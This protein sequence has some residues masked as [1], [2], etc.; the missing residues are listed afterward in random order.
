LPDD[1][2]YVTL[3]DGRIGRFDAS[4]TDDVIKSQ[5]LKDFPDAYGKAPSKTAAPVGPNPVTPQAGPPVSRFDQFVGDALNLTDPRTGTSL[6]D[7]FSGFQHY[8]NDPLKAAADWAG[9]KGS[10][11]MTAPTG[12]MTNRAMMGRFGLDPHVLTPEERGRASAIGETVGSTVGDIRNWPLML[13]GGPILKK[14]MGAGFATL[15]GANVIQ[16]SGE[17]GKVWDDNTPEGREARSKGLTGMTLGT[18]MAGLAGTGVRET[19]KMEGVGPKVEAPPTDVETGKIQPEEMASKPEPKAPGKPSFDT[20]VI[21][22]KKMGDSTMHRLSII[23]DGEE[24]GHISGIVDPTDPSTLQIHD[25]ELTAAERGNGLG[26]QAYEEFIN[27]AKE[28]GFSTLRSDSIV[29]PAAGRVWESLGKKGYDVQQVM[30]GLSGKQY[31]LR[32]KPEEAPAPTPFEALADAQRGTP[33]QA[34]LNI[35]RHPLGPGLYNY[36]VEHVGDLTHRMA[37]SRTDFGYET[38]K[39]KVTKSLRYL[40]QG[41]GFEKEVAQN[42]KN[43][44]KYLTEEKGYKGSFSDAENELKQR[45]EQYAQAHEQLP[46]V[47]AL[48]KTARDAA[49]ALGR[50]NF[51]TAR[52]KLT[53]LKT[54]LDKGKDAWTKAAG[55]TSDI[56]PAQDVPVDLGAAAKKTIT[57]AAT[58]KRVKQYMTKNGLTREDAGSRVYEDL[59]REGIEIPEVLKPQRTVASI[60]PEQHAS[61]LISSLKAKETIAPER[62]TEVEKATGVKLAGKEPNVQ[63]HALK[64]FQQSQLNVRAIESALTEKDPALSTHLPAIKDAI[65]KRFPDADA[66]QRTGNYLSALSYLRKHVGDA[67]RVE[68]AMDIATRKSEQGSLPGHRYDEAALKAIA[69]DHVGKILERYEPMGDARLGSEQVFDRL[70][71]PQFERAVADAKSPE[72]TKRWEALKV[73]SA[74]PNL[75]DPAEALFMDVQGQV[76][77]SGKVTEGIMRDYTGNLARDKEQLYNSLDKSISEWDNRSIADFGDFTD[78]MEHGDFANM[79]P[80]DQATAKTLRGLLDDRREKLQGLGTGK[81][82]TF[83]EN[84]FPHLWVANK[85]AAKYFSNLL[86]AKRSLARWQRIP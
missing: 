45:G 25:S 61:D 19:P 29:S 5:I 79:S 86:M 6:G 11:I 83:I 13:E 39:D 41:Y 22:P 49:V 69:Q 51:D 15:M 26:K 46:V 30:E 58:E 70:T 57:S 2:R 52:T 67:D 4:A 48:Q 55:E 75:P 59:Q 65:A 64:N 35:Q 32:L 28:S 68:K 36:V 62:L 47:N 14:A 10:E 77:T 56:R 31:E 72:L 42:R 23:R 78:K 20:Q 84:Y 73:R 71:S 54:V 1:S 33:E 74:P 34:M 53:E 82:D 27:H 40:N 18:A 12:E 81:L 76:L 16:Q 60:S 24:V 17:T 44:F 21:E 3:P 7:A 43:N 63:V 9:N 37:D 38:V 85:N 8:V 50:H 66:S 80:R